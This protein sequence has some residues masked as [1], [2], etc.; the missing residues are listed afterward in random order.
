[1]KLKDFDFR[2]WDNGQKYAGD[3]VKKYMG[4]SGFSDDAEVELWSGFYDK[5]GKKIYVG[6]MVK[7]RKYT[8]PLE[9]IYAESTF[10]IIHPSIEKEFQVDCGT[11]LQGIYD[12]RDNGYKDN[13]LECVEVIGNIHENAELRGQNE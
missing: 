1:M 3:V 6:D 4:L 11:R 10:Y 12:N 2:I 7:Y 13:K 9:V 5:N 8:K